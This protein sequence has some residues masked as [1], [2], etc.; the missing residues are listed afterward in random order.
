[1]KNIIVIT[2]DNYC[3]IDNENE[4]IELFLG[5]DYF[6]LNKEK[7]KERLLEKANQNSF[8][9]SIKMVSLNNKFNKNEPFILIDNEKNYILS[10]LKQN[11]FMILENRNSNVFILDEMKKETTDNYFII[12]NYVDKILFKS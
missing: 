12:N 11:K 4:L 2:D 9:G 8:G 7:Q 10:L 3:K 1:M 6:I 5:Y